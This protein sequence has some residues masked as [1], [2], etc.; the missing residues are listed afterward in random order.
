MRCG[1]C[2]SV[3]PLLALDLN[4][5]GIKFYK[6][7]CNYCKLCEFTCPVKAISVSKKVI[8]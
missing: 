5:Y 6:D 4:E 1:A 2:V 7:R 8:K 3:C